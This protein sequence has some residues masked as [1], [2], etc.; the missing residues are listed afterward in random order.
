MKTTLE[1]I[2]FACPSCQQVHRVP[3][4]FEGRKGSCS[5]CKQVLRVRRGVAELYRSRSSS[6]A[7]RAGEGRREDSPEDA[8]AWSSDGLRRA[9]PRPSSRRAS[10]PPRRPV[11]LIAALALCGAG[12]AA[13][14]TGAAVSLTRSSDPLASIPRDMDL[15][16]QA[17]YQSLLDE[18]ELL[19]LLEQ[20]RA[21]VQES[22][23]IDPVDDIERIYVAANLTKAQ[24]GDGEGVL[25]LIQGDLD[26]WALQAAVEQQ[27]MKFETRDYCGTSYLVAQG[28]PK[29]FALCLLQS[30]LLAV[31]TERSIQD[32]I[33]ATQGATPSI[34]DNPDLAPSIVG[35]R[36]SLLWC[37][38]HVPEGSPLTEGLAP[39]L[40]SLVLSADHE[41]GVL[42]LVSSARFDSEREAHAAQ[43]QLEQAFSGLDEQLLAS[44]LPIRPAALGEA[45]V[46]KSITR[47]EQTLELS[48][49]IDTAQALQAAQGAE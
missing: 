11:A 32:A 24:G 18:L 21:L 27:A 30:D 37:A 28:L 33:D 7:S 13:A 41:S 35:V 9:A 15:V 17:D 14:V 29:P 42:N 5:S 19:P 49:Q 39:G 16:V 22:A 6:S 8:Y 47:D 25:V 31:G 36:E 38:V 45:L 20:Q 2:R 10:T 43:G 46:G 26:L 48:V 1:S 44:P 12:F 23:A 40:R 34:L 4:E 3:A